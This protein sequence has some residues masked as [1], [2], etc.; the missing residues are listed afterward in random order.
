M[1]SSTMSVLDKIEMIADNLAPECSS[2][3]QVCPNYFS[4]ANSDCEIVSK[5][6]PSWS[7]MWTGHAW[8]PDQVWA[9]SYVW[10]KKHVTKG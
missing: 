7:V 8:K 1:L 3:M 6:I 9:H 10:D 2:R 5:I 4:E